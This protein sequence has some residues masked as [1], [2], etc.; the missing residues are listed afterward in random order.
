[1]ENVVPPARPLLIRVLKS[2]RTK[3]RRG[4]D[5]HWLTWGQLPVDDGQGSWC[6]D[7]WFIWV[8][9]YILAR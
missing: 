3:A 2:G 7:V 9:Q 1:M 5:C 6:Q 8:A 4:K